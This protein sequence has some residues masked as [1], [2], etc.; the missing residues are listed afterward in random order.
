[1]KE[2]GKCGNQLKE[3]LKG[4]DWCEG[5]YICTH[6]FG[7]GEKVGLPLRLRA[8]EQASGATYMNYVVL[9]KFTV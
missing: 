4:I 1:M 2:T 6:V 5:N 3:A 8:G 9:K 7:A